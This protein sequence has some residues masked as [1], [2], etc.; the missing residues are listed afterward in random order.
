MLNH[1][2]TTL[3]SGL[4]V[5]RVPMP[6]L[7]SVTVLALCNTGSRYERS[8]ER[9]IA[10][11]LEH[12]VFK[13]TKNYPDAQKL[14]IAI[15]QI[16][17][18]FNA[19]TSKEYTGYYVKAA[20]KHVE[21][22]LSVVSD[23]LLAPKLRQADIDREKGVIIEEINMYHDTPTAHV[24]NMFDHLFFAGSGLGYDIIGSKKTVKSLKSQNLTNFLG[25]WYGLGN[26]V[27]VLAGNEKVVAGD[28]ILEQV[29]EFW[30]RGE[31]TDKVDV[32]RFLSDRGGS[33]DN[34]R[35]DNRATEK[36]VQGVMQEVVQD[37]TKDTT[38]EATQNTNQRF[39]FEYRQT[40]QTHLAL[41][42]PG[43]NRD[44]A[45]RYALSVLTTVLG[46]NMSSRLFTEVREKRGL[47]Y[48]VRCDVD[49]Y[50]DLGMVGASAGVGPKRID[51]ALQVIVDEFYKIAS[52]NQPITSKELNNAKE[53]IIGSMTLSL[54]DSLIV[55][56]Y[57]GLK[58]LLLDIVE[59]PATTIEQLQ[60]VGL[61]DVH[62]IARH[63][64]EKGKL[65]LALLGPYRRR[66]SLLDFV[67]KN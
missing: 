17:A 25:E 36:V 26:I 38:Q 50:H 41:G 65:H 53:H 37:A 28:T 67:E 24:Q 5:L 60:A 56:Q 62:R 8:S 48:Y 35:G 34:L 16:G 57:Y 59:S 11:F 23:M 18:D 22:A 42:W 55:A 33:G 27:L 45:D 54:E 29:A 4:T 52:G 32:G 3:D 15:D 14:A 9:G 43:I 1:S 30:G 21:R 39:G 7:E 66:Q 58:K 19:F 44:H 46:G 63:L 2:L 64:F 10:H 61:D 40:D 49:R 20:A 31:S 13:G 6:S 51:E 47:C 12:M